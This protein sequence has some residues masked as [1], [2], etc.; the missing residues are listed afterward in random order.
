ML[1]MEK[2]RC[3]DC[4]KVLC[5]RRCRMIIFEHVVYLL[6]HTLTH[7]SCKL[8]LTEF[9]MT[10]ADAPKFSSKVG[11]PRPVS[12]EVGRDFQLSMRNQ[13]WLECFGWELNMSSPLENP[14]FFFIPHCNQPP[15]I[16]TSL[17]H[18]RREEN[19]HERTKYKSRETAARSMPSAL[20][21]DRLTPGDPSGSEYPPSPTHQQSHFTFSPNPPFSSFSKWRDLIPFWTP[22]LTPLEILHSFASIG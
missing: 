7:H 6:T 4:R 9:E 20:R 16:T 2:G 15:S 3:L 19:F 22:S 1:R 21:N 17:A 11:L 14:F 13:P 18:A 10:D 5:S 12:M 8:A